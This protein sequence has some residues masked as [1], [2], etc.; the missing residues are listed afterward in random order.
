MTNREDKDGAG[1]RQWPPRTKVPLRR[2][3][4]YHLLDVVLLV[5]EKKAVAILM[6]YETA[7][8]AENWFC[9]VSV[10]LSFSLVLH[11]NGHHMGR[12]LMDRSTK[13]GKL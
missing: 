7:I 12:V 13:V 2:A 6:D 9:V 8:K 11:T 4:L 3:N 5:L 10:F 1:T